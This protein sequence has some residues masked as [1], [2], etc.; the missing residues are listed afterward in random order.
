MLTYNSSSLC[1]FY[2]NPARLIAANSNLS[3]WKWNPWPLDWKSNA[4]P[5]VRCRQYKEIFRI[6]WFVESV[7]FKCMLNAKKTMTQHYFCTIFRHWTRWRV[8]VLA[9]TGPHFWT[10][11][12]SRH[13]VCLLYFDVNRKVENIDWYGLIS[14]YLKISCWSH[15]QDMNLAPQL[16]NFNK[17]NC[18]YINHSN[19]V[20]DVYKCQLCASCYMHISHIHSSIFS[21]FLLCVL[22]NLWFCNWHCAYPLVCTCVCFEL[23]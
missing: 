7:Y 17:I 11:F 12:G 1:D 8:I 9:C 16:E 21:I 20:S 15:L 14:V 23:F 4:L 6:R 2:V 10:V 3:K 18:T 22:W 13:F 5:T 19:Y